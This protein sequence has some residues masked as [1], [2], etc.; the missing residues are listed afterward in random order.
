MFDQKLGLCRS[1]IDRE[2]VPEIMLLLTSLTGTSQSIGHFWPG[3]ADSFGALLVVVAWAVSR[4]TPIYFMYNTGQRQSFIVAIATLFHSSKKVKKAITGS[5]KPDCQGHQ[6][7]HK[8]DD[9]VFKQN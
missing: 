8:N 5:F 6:H 1:H 2:D 3:F 4:K 9:C 7:Q